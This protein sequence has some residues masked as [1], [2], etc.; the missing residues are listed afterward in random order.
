MFIATRI[1]AC[2]VCVSAWPVDCVVT[3]VHLRRHTS[4]CTFIYTY[5]YVCCPEPAL[6]RG[7][8]W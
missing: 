3:A 1:V 4:I 8:G 2:M 5:M 6:A 7:V